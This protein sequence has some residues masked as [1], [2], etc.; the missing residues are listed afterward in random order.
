MGRAGLD[1]VGRLVR[2]EAETE[3]A[4][5]GVA[6]NDGLVRGAH[7]DRVAPQPAQHPHLG[8]RLVRRPGQHDVDPLAEADP[9]PL[10]RVAGRGA[11]SRVVGIGERREARPEAIEV[12]A[13]QRIVTGEVDVIGDQ[14][15]V[16]RLELRIEATG[17]V[18]EHERIDPERKH[19]AQQ[20][21]RL[22]MRVA[23]IWVS[24]PRE[25]DDR[26]PVTEPAMSWPAWPSTPEPGTCGMSP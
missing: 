15:H 7:A 5:A 8:A 17:G 25:D 9:G 20:E 14:H 11:Q 23:L 16:A 2:D 1:V 13:E 21:C 3:H 4:R 10:G 26:H 18:G 12:R 22:A 19:R 6:R 24:P